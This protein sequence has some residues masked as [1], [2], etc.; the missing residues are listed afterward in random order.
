MK[1]LFTSFAVLFAATA[2]FAQTNLFHPAEASI[3]ETYFAPNWNVDP[4]STATY[5]AATG[6][7]QVHI[8][9]QLLGTWQG[10]VKL[11]HNVDFSATKKYQFSCKFQSTLAFG[12]VTVK[13]D[14][15]VPVVLNS[16]IQLPAN[17]AYV[18]TEEGDGQAGNN[19]VLV[20]DFG[21]AGPCDITISDISIVETGDAE[22][23]EHPAPAPMPQ[24]DAT[25]VFSIYSDAY[26]TTVQRNTGGWGQSTV[27]LEVSLG[28][29]DKAFYLTK[30]SYLGWELNGNTTIGDMSQFP[31]FHMDIYVAEASSIKFTP[32][33]GAEAAKE[34][35]LVAGWNA[36]DIDLAKDFPAIDMQNIYQLK[37]D[38][39]PATCYIDNVYFYTEATS[40]DNTQ[41]EDAARKMI[42]DG[43]F[44]IQQGSRI[45]T[46]LGIA[47]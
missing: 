35:P 27:E 39:M 24:R 30:A 25:N 22:V 6:T 13:M 32:I 5:D 33:W 3:L 4:N 8:A 46:V 40:I 28:E 2:L 41:V 15:N 16:T 11:T 20:F 34:Y 12:G 47:R 45:Y 10:Q 9:S 7:I 37:W 42:K 29:A 18:F 19:K 36:M 23:V 43:V 21:W 31:L 17:E 26:T 44:Y 38:A 14:D 1:K